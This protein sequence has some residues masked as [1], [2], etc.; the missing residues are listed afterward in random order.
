M[1]SNR[2][3]N[4]ADKEGMES[5]VQAGVVSD[6]KNAAEGDGIEMIAEMTDL[7]ESIKML[8]TV[9]LTRSSSAKT[10]IGA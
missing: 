5:G 3:W 8:A 7:S 6:S 1:V 9:R 2:D 4:K 10:R